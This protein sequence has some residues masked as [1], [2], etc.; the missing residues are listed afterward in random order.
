MV[1]SLPTPT[2]ISVESSPAIP[3]PDMAKENQKEIMNMWLEIDS[4]K[5]ALKSIE[6]SV[7]SLRNKIEEVVLKCESSA[8]NQEVRLKETLSSVYSTVSTYEDTLKSSTNGEISKLTKNLDHK[9]SNMKEEMRKFK[10]TF[11]EQMEDNVPQET[12]LSEEDEMKLADLVTQLKNNFKKDL[13]EVDGVYEERFTEIDTQIKQLNEEIKSYLTNREH[14]SD[15][16]QSQNTLPQNTTQESIRRATDD[17]TV[18]VMCMDSNGK[19]LDKRKLWDLDGTKYEK[20]FTLDEVSNVVDRDIQYNK[21][22]Y[23]FI[24]VGCNDC[25]S[26]D[27]ESVVEKLKN[28]VSR[29]KSRYPSIKTIVSEITPRQD[30]RDEIVKEANVLINRFVENSD[31]V[32]VVRNSNL[33]NSN[34]TFHEDNKHIS[35]ECIA[36]FAANIKHALRVAYGRRKYDPANQRSHTNSNHS[37]LHQQPHFQMQQQQQQ[38]QQIHQLLWF[39][40]NNAQ[41]Q[42]GFN[43]HNN[44]GFAQPVT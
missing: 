11:E 10:C 30:N 37:T 17:S 41:Q 22:K 8:S 16:S 43:D 9:I 14:S 13:N 4:F 34:Y 33:R 2:G 3:D 7:S 15:Q 29:L 5:T 21:L 1:S 28:I 23:F 42:S 18:L 25:D 40:K 6:D 44:Y 38:Q 12:K 36:K 20:T 19:Y 35:S 31:R 24:S 26:E 27:A 39:L 32:Y